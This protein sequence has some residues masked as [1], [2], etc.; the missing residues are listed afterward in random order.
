MMGLRAWFAGRSLRERR[1]ILVM[2]ALLAVTIVWAG[3]I[4]PVRDGLASARDRHADA[5]MRLGETQNAV[6]ALKANRRIRPLTG[7]L[8]DVVRA[9]ATAAGF[10]IGTLDQQGAGRVHLTIQSGRG[11]ALSAWL[12]R[13]ERLGILVEAATLRDTGNGTLAADLVVRSRGT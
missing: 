5:V 11:P 7:S 4:R 8:A 3:V 10:T 2:L 12:A 1:M 13:L 9:E 6:D